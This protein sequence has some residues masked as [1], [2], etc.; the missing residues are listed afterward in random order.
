VLVVVNLDTYHTQA[1]TVHLDLAALGQHPG[2]TFPV[3]DAVTGATW[4]WGE[5]NYVR[6]VPEV[7]VAH[8]LVLPTVA[9]DQR[10]ALA[11]RNVTDYRA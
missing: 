9:A 1:G 7:D 8:I 10:E 11:W 3:H 4:T 2:A 6:L 5:H